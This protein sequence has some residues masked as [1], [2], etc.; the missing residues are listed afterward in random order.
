MSDTTAA[1]A[2]PEGR[3]INLHLFVPQRYKDPKTGRKGDPSYSVEMAYSKPAEG[4]EGMLSPFEDY[5]WAVMVE[6]YGEAKVKE[7]D[8]ADM[9]RWPIK[10]GNVK[11]ANREAAEKQGDAYKGMDIVSARTVFDKNGDRITLNESESVIAG[12]QGVDVFDA[13]VE[14]IA[15]INKSQVYN[16]CMGVVAI[17][18]KAYD[19]TSR[20]TGKPFISCAL[21]LEAFQMTGEGERL[22]SQGNKSS[23]F[24]KR[25]A[26]GGGEG[27]GR[28]TRS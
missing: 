5:L 7:Y 22:A 11:A 20:D 28:R 26:S 8:E 12:G 2:M 10:D 1:F 18:A 15:P 13:N 23:L 24:Q 9:I 14:A 4:Q 21:Y 6:K 27:S 3:G 25:P 16:G 19:D 17:K